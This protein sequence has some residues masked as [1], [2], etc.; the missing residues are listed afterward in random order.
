QIVSQSPRKHVSSSKSVHDVWKQLQ[1]IESAKEDRAA[2]WLSKTR[3]IE[4]P[5]EVLKCGFANLT[6]ADASL[7][8]SSHQSF[9]T[10][11]TGL[12]AQIVVP[13]RSAKS[14]EVKNLFFRSITNVLK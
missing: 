9:I 4:D 2:E 7:F 1:R 10:H 11:R 3:G 14:N 8:D 13:L 5:R 6:K 12:G